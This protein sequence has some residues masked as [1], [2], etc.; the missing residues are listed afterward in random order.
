M[1][2]C[3]AG[4]VSVPAPVLAATPSARA[5]APDQTLEKGC[6]DYRY[7]YRVRN[8]EDWMLELVVRD[9]DGR[10]VASATWFGNVDPDK[11]VRTFELCRASVEPGRYTIRGTLTERAGWQQ[12]EHRVRKSAFRL[13][14]G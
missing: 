2:L 14:K 1:V 4:L 9:P 6:H 5:S 7:R 11:A 3:A 12:T 13:R 8:A 10:S